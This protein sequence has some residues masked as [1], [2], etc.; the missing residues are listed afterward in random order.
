MKEEVLNTVKSDVLKTC[1]SNVQKGTAKLSAYELS[2]S[3]IPVSR[4]SCLRWK[5]IW[6]RRIS[7]RRKKSA[8]SMCSDHSVT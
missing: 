1:R 6:A 2:A 4:R 3:P 7:R 8:R 5:L